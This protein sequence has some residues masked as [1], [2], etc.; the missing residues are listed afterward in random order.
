MHSQNIAADLANVT[1]GFKWVL[2]TDLLD[3]Y[4]SSENGLHKAIIRFLRSKSACGMRITHIDGDYNRHKSIFSR[5]ETYDTPRRNYLRT[6]HNSTFT[7]KNGSEVIWKIFQHPHPVFWAK[8]ISG[9]ERPYIKEKVHI[10][11]LRNSIVRPIYPPRQSIVRQISS[12]ITISG[13]GHRKLSP[14]ITISGL[15]HRQK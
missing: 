10:C 7:P 11:T 8:D 15:K 13:L 12:K 2:I 14:E 4:I 6:Q 3:H 1:A 9:S 5:P